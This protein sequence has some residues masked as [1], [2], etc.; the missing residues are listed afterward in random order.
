MV[1]TARHSFS[2]LLKQETTPGIF[3][4]L[5]AV[6]ALI[7]DKSPPD[8]IYDAPPTTPVAA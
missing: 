1:A 5:A 2:A 3:P 7:I 6:L 8:R 4:M